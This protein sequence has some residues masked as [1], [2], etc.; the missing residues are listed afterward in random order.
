MRL[1]DAL[2]DAEILSDDSFVCVTLPDDDAD[3]EPLLVLL[4][5]MDA[6]RERLSEADIEDDVV[7]LVDVD[8]D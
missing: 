7:S 8:E 6:S 1:V 4:L 2:T 5:V 3:C